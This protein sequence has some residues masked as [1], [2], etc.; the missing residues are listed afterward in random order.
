MKVFDVR[1][2][3]NGACFGLGSLNKYRYVSFLTFKEWQLKKAL[4]LLADAS[5]DF[6]SAPR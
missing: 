1:V 6:V 2:H 4:P 5:L 3:D